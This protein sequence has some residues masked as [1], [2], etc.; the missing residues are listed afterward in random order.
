VLPLRDLDTGATLQV[1]RVLEMLWAEVRRER[2]EVGQTAEVGS[3]GNQ[4]IQFRDL[5]REE[6]SLLIA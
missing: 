6:A 4:K 3:F 5:T 1:L 2:G